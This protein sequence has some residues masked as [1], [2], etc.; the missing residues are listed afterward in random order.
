MLS[1]VYPESKAVASGVFEDLGISWTLVRNTSVPTHHY[2][3]Y[4]R[5]SKC[6]ME[7]TGYDRI[8][9][10]VPVHGGITYAESDEYGYVYGFDCAHLGDEGRPELWDEDFL[11]Q[12]CWRLAKAIQIAA[13]YEC[14][15]EL[16]TDQQVRAGILDDFTAEMKRAGI[17]VDYSVNFGFMLK[18][19][20]GKL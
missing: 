8:L 9:T 13:K 1:N 19:L 3:G 15:Y 14:S 17:N 11:R 2:C 5:F 6:P 4:V 10:Y 18:V 12:E 20:F 16:R 7:N